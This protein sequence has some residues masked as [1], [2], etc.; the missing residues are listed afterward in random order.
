MVPSL[1][2]P[3]FMIVKTNQNAVST[4]FEAGQKYI[5]IIKPRAR[6]PL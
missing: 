4:P 3:L 1:R 6:Q 2:V 5:C